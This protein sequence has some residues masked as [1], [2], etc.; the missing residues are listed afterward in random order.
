MSKPNTY[1]DLEEVGR[2]PPVIREVTTNLVTECLYVTRV[3][4][5]VELEYYLTI[6]TGYT[7]K[8]RLLLDLGSGRL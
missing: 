2:T 5:K 4:Y 6:L 7:K 8:F 1:S 3:T